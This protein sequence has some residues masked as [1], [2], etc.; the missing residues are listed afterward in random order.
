MIEFK[1]GSGI[2]NC[3]CWLEET[4]YLHIHNTL[5]Y[6]CYVK[7]TS[8]LINKKK[9]SEVVEK[10]VAIGKWNHMLLDSSVAKEENTGQAHLTHV[11]RYDKCRKNKY[12]V[13]MCSLLNTFKTHYIA[14]SIIWLLWIVPQ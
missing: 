12:L 6:F 7:E 3:N 13:F 5:L 10:D 11:S 2:W 8:S 14:V 4:L 1:I 9:F